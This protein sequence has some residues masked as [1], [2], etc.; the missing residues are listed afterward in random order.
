MS[1]TVYVYS[2]E[3]T[4]YDMGPQHPMQ[5]IRLTRTTELLSKFGAFDTIETVRPVQATR[6]ALNRVHHPDYVDAVIEA[7]MHPRSV[8]RQNG[9]GLGTGDNPVF[10]GMYEASALYTGASIQAANA[11]LEGADVAI[12]I[13]GGL[14]HA[15]YKRAAGFCVFNDCAAAIQKLREKFDR[16][17]YVD[18]D[19]HHGDGVQELFYGDPA[20]LTISIHESG[21]TLFPGTGFVGEMGEGA[22]LGYSVNVPLAPNTPDDIWLKAWRSGGL[23]ALRQFKPQTIVLQ[24]GTD[25]HY[26]DPL[27][28][29]CLTAQGW[30]EAVKDVRELGVPIVGIGGGGYNPTTVP[31][32]WTL[33]VAELAGLELPDAT[34]TNFSYHDQIPFLRDNVE[35]ELSDN[36]RNSAKLAAE[37]AVRQIEK[38]ILPLIVIS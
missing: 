32:M 1:R 26:L 12:N 23:A 14:H 17:A 36:E 16:V 34:P 20:V 11:V 28:H 21:K 33:A 10:T 7:G 4:G 35:L 27:A 6:A 38:D 31:R 19:V 22:G 37:D 8:S 18:I 29:I 3:L 13:A 5:P 2:D 25:A 15:H 9:F 30:L 24:M